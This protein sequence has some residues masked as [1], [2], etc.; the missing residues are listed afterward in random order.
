MDEKRAA[1]RA[2]SPPR[3]LRRSRPTL[4]I[5]FVIA[6]VY[7][8]WIWQ[9]FNPILD[10]TMVD[11]TSDDVHTTDRL[12]PLEAHI[13]SKCPDAK[14]G[15]ELLVLPVM[16]RVHDKVNFT[17][18]YIGR[19]TANDGVDCMH[20]PSE[21]MGNIIELCARELYPDPK[22]NLGFIMCLSRD[23]SEI[24]ERSLVEDC[25]LESAIDFQQLNDCAVKEDGAYG[26][27]LLRDSIKRTADAGVTKSA[28]IRL[29][30]K[31]YCI[32]DG[33]EWTDCPNGSGVNDL[34]IAIEKLRR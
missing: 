31:I 2:M 4:T 7:T 6:V 16:Q 10:Q 19:P 5:A 8:F 33:G 22:I 3:S 30:N 25:A 32:R 18:S 24:P 9:P 15:L 34:I 27:S 20:G 14:D 28:T 17:L 1:P 21:C 23:Y 29:D 26:L 13:M 11:I 12:V